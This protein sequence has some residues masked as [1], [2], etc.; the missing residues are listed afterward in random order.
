MSTNNEQRYVQL[1]KV[2][3]QK[4]ADLQA[5]IERLKQKE[6]EPIAIVGMGC[7]L[8]PADNPEEFWD[9]LANGVDAIR[10]A[11]KGHHAYL[12]PYY[13]PE[14]SLPG[15]IY[16]NRAAFL[17]QS[18]ADFDASFFGISP[19]EAASL[20]PQ[21]RLLMEVAWEALERASLVPE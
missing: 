5:E 6:R 2:A 19:Q 1:M 17:N 4:I 18:P 20:D 9:L 21:H 13:D 8:G 3:S 10:E 15:K 16:I 12:D 7:R 14:S 11:P